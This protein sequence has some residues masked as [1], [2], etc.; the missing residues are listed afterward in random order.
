MERENLRLYE[1]ATRYGYTDANYVSR[2]YKR[3]FGKNITD[4]KKEG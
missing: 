1:A 2:L 3:Y 4:F